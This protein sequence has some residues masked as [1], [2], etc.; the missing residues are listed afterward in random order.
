MNDIWH[1]K[2]ILN[3]KQ[4]AFFSKALE[5]V[6]EFESFPNAE[7]LNNVFPVNG[8]TFVAQ[9]TLKVRSFRMRKK[10]KAQAELHYDEYICQK[11]IIPVR[12]N[13]WHDFFNALIW[14][15]FPC[16]KKVIYQ[17]FL[18]LR[19]SRENPCIRSSEEDRLTLLDEGGEIFLPNEKSV[20]FGHAILENFILTPDR[21]I[22]SFKLTLS[23]PVEDQELVQAFMVD[24]RQNCLLLL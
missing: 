11:G 23:N 20:I 21:K 3:F 9:K 16:T 10:T 2:T 14:F 13:N 17:K 4:S 15:F 12:E 18:N 19:K 6:L 5:N 1:P 8:F 7:E 22:N 24:L